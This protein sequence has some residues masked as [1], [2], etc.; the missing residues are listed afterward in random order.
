MLTLPRLGIFFVAVMVDLTCMTAYAE[1][2]K[3]IDNDG[4]V[5]Y[6]DKPPNGKI[7]RS[8]DIRP[9]PSGAQAQSADERLHRLLE[10]QRHL[11]QTRE[12]EKEQRKEV[13][14]EQKASDNRCY[15]AKVQLE[16]LKAGEAAYMDK[17]GQYQSH[18]SRDSTGYKGQRRY[19]DDT[20]RAL[21]IEKYEKVL[22]AHCSGEKQKER[23]SKLR[24]AKSCLRWREELVEL[25]RPDLR[26][27]DSEIK[28]KRDR[29]AKYCN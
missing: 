6:T 16:Q 7:S 15:A 8:I 1:V 12:A 26:T 21:A 5:Q 11:E 28:P 9:A 19:I 25:E 3:W 4:N 22:E 23:T 24:E 10:Q 27:P 13:A 29:I 14:A 2:Y 20:E 17:T 18:W